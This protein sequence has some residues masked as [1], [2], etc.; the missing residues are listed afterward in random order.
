MSADVLND[1]MTTTGRTRRSP[2]ALIALAIQALEDISEL[3]RSAQFIAENIAALSESAAGI[4]RHAE[5]IATQITGLSESAHGI[6][7]HAEKIA[8]E[9]GLI[10][11]RLPT[12]QRLAEVIDPLESTVARLGWIADRIPGGKR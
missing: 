5:T 1:P 9:A 11:Q 12:I 3:R 10:S 7:V 6:D 4:N 8:A 2:R